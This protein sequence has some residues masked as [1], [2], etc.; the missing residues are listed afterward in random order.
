MNARLTSLALIALLAGATPLTAQD[1]AD[2]AWAAGEHERARTLYA[3][4][5]AAD[6]ADAQALHRLGLLLGWNREYAAAIRVLD[7]LMAVAPTNAVRADR[8]NVLAWSRNYE[9]ALADVDELIRS[10]STSLEAW[11]ARARFLSWAG[12]YDESLR[13]WDRVERL[14][15]GDTGVTHARARVLSWAGRLG[16]AEEAYWTSLAANPGDVEAM[17]GLAR[18]T[19]WRGDLATGE[20]LWRRAVAADPAS[21]EA[22]IGLSQVLRWR[23]QPAASLEEARE[24]VRLD[25]EN[26]DAQLQLAWAEAAFAPRIAPAFSAA[27]DSDDNRLLTSSLAVTLFPAHRVALTASGYLRRAQDG[28][29]G[30]GAVDSRALTLAARTDIGAG[31]TVGASGGVKDRDVP[32]AEADFTF[33]G[34]LASA[35]WRP[36]SGA[37]AYTRGV[38]DATA[39]LIEQ[40]VTTDEVALTVAAQLARAVRLEAGAGFMRFTGVER[41]ERVLARL[42]LDVR[43]G[44]WLRV[45]PRALGFGFEHDLDEGYFDPDRY[46][47][48]EVGVGVDRYRGAWALSGEVAP[49]AQQVGSDGDVQGALSGSARVGYTLAPGREIGIGF[50]FSNLGM[51]RFDPDRTGYR[52]GAAV[53]SAAWGL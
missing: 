28:R 22:R 7:R 42:G 41:N 9:R 34:S 3:A 39:R 16:A 31:W 27:F 10:D 20:Q 51:E 29:A 4:R 5:V 15:P 8:A 1:A 50:T 13:A 47:L 48:G 36:V 19:S 21:A 38:F 24:A 12:R 14:A 32:G 40:G 53:I 49:G 52:Y 17:R 46:L 23:G 2:S 35:P 43:A 37:V 44:S 30:G 25:P 26:R 11:T 45:R 6:S 18:V 33:G